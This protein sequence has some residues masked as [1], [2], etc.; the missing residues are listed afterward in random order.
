MTN[1][2]K[3]L[4]SSHSPHPSPMVPTLLTL[5]SASSFSLDI[6]R[7]LST[8]ATVSSSQSSS[9]KVFTFLKIT[10]GEEEKNKI[11]WITN[12]YS[13]SWCTY[14]LPAVR[15]Y[16]SFLLRSLFSFRAASF[17]LISFC[18]LMYTGLIVSA[19]IGCS[20]VPSSGA[21]DREG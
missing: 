16:P 7:L 6:F 3:Q 8:Q 14:S 1:T 18:C 15:S 17:S 2:H 21:A 10:A 12:Y 4:L 13:P 20:F 5:F 9:A 19:T 11:N